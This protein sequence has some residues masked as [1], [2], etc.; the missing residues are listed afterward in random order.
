MTEAID[1]IAVETQPVPLLE[2]RDG[3]PPVVADETALAAVVAAFAAGTG[4]VAVDAE[5]A[6]GYRYGQRAYLIQLRRAGAGT[7]LIDPAACTDLSALGEALADAEWVVHA[8]TQDLP[9]LAEVGMR[10]RQLFDTELAGRIAGF[11]RVGLGPMTESVLGYTL[12]KE[13]SA[14]DWSTRPLPEPW[15]RYAALDVEVLVELRDALEQELDGQGKLEWAL[16]EFAAIAAAPR[17][18]P[19]VDPWRRTSGLHKVRRRR[20]LAAV[21]EL[22]QARD[23]IAQERDVSPGRVLSDAAIVAAALAMPLNVPALQAVQGFGPRVHRRQLEQW[24]AALERARAIPEAQLP[25]ATAPHEGPPPPRAWAE[26]D[27]V[28]AARLSAAR[29]AVTE[30]A[31][32][33]NLPAENLITPELVRR[34]SWEPPAEATAAT[35]AGALRTLGARRWQVELVAPVLATAFETAAKTPPSE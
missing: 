24:M 30:L 3:L 28:A 32:Q 25:P 23:R 5:R 4:P 27:P 7:A 33:N 6:S 18:T 13:H 15:L 22:W 14:V 11:P 29:A 19:R 10:P 8:A 16:E 35:I 21:R 17:A 9:C 1:A 12:A 2:P 20:Q 31:E 34:V 26:K